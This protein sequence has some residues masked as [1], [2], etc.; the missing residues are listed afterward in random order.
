MSLS[1]DINTISTSLSDIKDAIIL[2]GITPSGNITTYATAIGQISSSEPGYLP[3]EVKNGVYQQMS[4]SFTFS[5]P[6]TAT[7]LGYKVLYFAFDG[8]TSLTSVDLLSL[9]AVSGN[10]ALA[11]S[12]NGCTSLTS[13]NL[14]SLTTISG[15][16]ALYYVFNGCISLTSAD[17]SSLTTVSGDYGLSSTFYGCT[18]LA[19]LSFPSLTTVSGNYAL[20]EIFRNC[21]SLTSVSFP[22]LVSLT[23]HRA[24]YGAFN[25]THITSISFPKLTTLSGTQC[26]QYAFSYCTSLASVSFPAL[27]SSSFSTAT[28]QFNLMLNAVT[29]CTVHFPSNLQSAIGSWSDVTAG[30][31]GTNTTVLFDLP[32]TT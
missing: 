2:K 8:C 15:S 20:N 11:Y 28:S 9:T 23:S 25:G 16:Y 19:S 6:S 4:E 29:G 10:Y 1:D 17:L 30:F 14:S 31:G 7:D 21:T 26:L 13:A 27:T 24:F 5:V 22:E 3:R 18:G 12:F 32:A